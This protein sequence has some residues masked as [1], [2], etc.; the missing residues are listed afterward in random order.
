MLSRSGLISRRSHVHEMLHI[1]QPLFRYAQRSRSVL[2]SKHCG[3]LGATP[4]TASSASPRLASPIQSVTP[5]LELD[6][7]IRS[8]CIDPRH[9][10]G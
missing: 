7:S 5:S 4:S 10:H 3:L 1:C 2:R 6:P 8:P 9:S